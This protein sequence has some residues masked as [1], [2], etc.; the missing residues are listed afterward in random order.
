MKKTMPDFQEDAFPSANPIPFRH[1]MAMLSE[2]VAVLSL[3]R[4]IYANTALCEMVGKNRGEIIGCSFLSLVVDSDRE[5]VSDCLR[6]LDM[7]SPEPII[8]G[9][10][11]STRAG[12]LVRLK[13]SSLELRGIYEDAPGICCSL[14]DVTD[15]EDRINELE[16]ENRRMRSHLDESESVLMDM[17]P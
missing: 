2:G 1:V 11:R 17:A 14:T 5:R 12:R 6:Q 15:Y 8:F 4:V 10:Q 7:G 3:G 9:L 16:R 13:V